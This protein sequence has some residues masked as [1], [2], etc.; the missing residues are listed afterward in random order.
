MAS[1]LT[2][3][4]T[5]SVGDV[6]TYLAANDN[7]K[8]V[9]FGRRIS[10]PKSPIEMLMDTDSIRWSYN[11]GV[12]DIEDM[13]QAANYCRWEYGT[14]GLEAQY[15]ISGTGGGSV[16]PINGGTLP[17]PIQFIVSASSYMVDGQSSA[18]ISEFIGFNLLFTRGGISQSTVVS[19]P[20]YYTWDRDTGAF[21][22]SPILYAGELIQLYP[23]G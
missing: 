19:E 14:Y 5:I 7:S 3:P 12:N 22:C 17:L 13:R 9:L 15:I 21:T 23:I 16:I 1:L 10:S 6:S 18:T 20:T 11:G 8:G 4:V 2:I